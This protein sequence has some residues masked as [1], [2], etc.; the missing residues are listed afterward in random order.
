MGTHSLSYLYRGRP[1]LI[2]EVW[3]KEKSKLNLK[4]VFIGE[5]KYTEKLSTF[6]K[7]LK[8][9]I[10]YINFAS[11]KDNFL[12]SNK[13]K[14]SGILIV[15]GLKFIVDKEYK[16]DNYDI[17]IFDSNSINNFKLNLALNEAK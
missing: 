12:I 10:E 1:D 16:N 4:K 6:S 2:I 15:D 7:G 5:I 14:V 17:Q 11:Y 8:E 9:L 3:Q 13:M